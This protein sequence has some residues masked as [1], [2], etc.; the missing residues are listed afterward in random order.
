[1]TTNNEEDTSYETKKA[2]RIAATEVRIGR[3]L[4][5]WEQHMRVDMFH[6]A[7]R[8]L[9]SYNEEGRASLSDMAKKRLHHAA[10]FNRRVNAA[11]ALMQSGWSW[12][13][14]AMVLN[15]DSVTMN[16]AKSL[17]V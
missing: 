11:K 15:A 14:T 13:D 1:M 16:E 10:T 2:E 17:M 8:G 5:M 12:E 3:K 9:W 6:P 4:T 7:L